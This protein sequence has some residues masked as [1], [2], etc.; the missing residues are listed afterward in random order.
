MLFPKVVRGKKLL[1][2]S[3]GVAAISYACST[4]SGVSSGNLMAP[5]HDSGST[6]DGPSDD[7]LI[8]SGNLAAPVDSGMVEDSGQSGDAGTD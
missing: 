1:V 8:S 5:N 7:A 6:T 3:V 4:S 2:A